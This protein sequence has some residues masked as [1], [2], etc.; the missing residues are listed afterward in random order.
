MGGGEER[1]GP[2]APGTAGAKAALTIVVVAAATA[3]VVATSVVWPSVR[4]RPRTALCSD[5]GGGVSRCHQGRDRAE[6][7]C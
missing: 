4:A 5:G 3:A 1:C 2:T 6:R 7:I